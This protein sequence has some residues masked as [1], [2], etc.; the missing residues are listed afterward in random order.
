MTVT[1]NDMKAFKY[2]NRGARAFFERHALDW[3]DF[4]KNGIDA[5]KLLRTGDEMAAQLVEF[6]MIRRSSDG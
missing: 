4:V 6:A 3:P 5:E 1:H 2:C